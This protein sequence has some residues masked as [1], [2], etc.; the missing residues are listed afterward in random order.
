MG[1]GDFRPPWILESRNLST[2]FHKTW[3]LQLSPGD[4][5]Q[6]KV[7]SDPTTW[8]V[9]ANSQFAT[10]LF[11]SHRHKNGHQACFAPRMFLLG[12]EYL[13]FKFDPNYPV[14]VK[15]FWPQIGQAKILKHESPSISENTKPMV[16]KI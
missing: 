11:V 10:T 13:R 2:D 12:L 7:D 14:N 8:V 3:N 15:Q 1:K 5:P 9:W 16:V 6:A 4:L